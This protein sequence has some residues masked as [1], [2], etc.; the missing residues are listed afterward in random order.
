MAFVRHCCRNIHFKISV[1]SVRQCSVPRITRPQRDFP[2][3]ADREVR[4]L[5]QPKTY[6]QRPTE[7]TEH[8]DKQS[9]DINSIIMDWI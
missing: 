5:E 4:Q 6:R 9:V 3:R 7:T 8:E 2:D 1:Q